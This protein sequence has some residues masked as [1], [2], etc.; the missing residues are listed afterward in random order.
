[1]RFKTLSGVMLK[2]S[3]LRPP[4]P[5]GVQVP[6]FPRTRFKGL[7]MALIKSILAVDRGARPTR[8]IFENRV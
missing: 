3:R 1:M 4:L 7:R 6:T 5:A 8:K 2:L